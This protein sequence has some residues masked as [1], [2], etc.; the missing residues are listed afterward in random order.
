M[1]ITEASRYSAAWR[2]RRRRMVVF[3]T[4]QFLLFPI[5]LGAEF[6]SS[7]NPCVGEDSM[8]PVLFAFLA[9]ILGYVIAGIWLNRF[10]CPR[11]GKLYYWRLEW[12]GALERQKNWRACHHCGL[13]QDALPS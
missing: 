3:R 6:L 4:V 9:W 1:E 5:V 12:K 11:C 10:R 2:D 7:K 8:P 13:Q